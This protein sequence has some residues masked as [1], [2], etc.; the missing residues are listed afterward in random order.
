MYVGADREVG[1]RSR[2]GIESTIVRVFCVYFIVGFFGEDS[3]PLPAARDAL[4]FYCS[5]YENGFVTVF[6]QATA[7]TALHVRASAGI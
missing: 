4:R 1:T 2:D 5:P 3:S 6:I 7:S